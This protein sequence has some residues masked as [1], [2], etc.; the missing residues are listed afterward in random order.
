M[1]FCQDRNYL[2]AEPEQRRSECADASS[3]FRFRL[4]LCLAIAPP[5]GR[6]GQG[7]FGALP[8]N[9]PAYFYIGIDPGLATDNYVLSPELEFRPPGSSCPC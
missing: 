4:Y 8:P 5:V 7:P 6:L 9:G 3:G 2:S 1:F